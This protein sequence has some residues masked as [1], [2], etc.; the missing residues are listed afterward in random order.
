MVGDFSLG[1]ISI[2]VSLFL[3]SYLP[4]LTF[5]LQQVLALGVL[6]CIAFLLCWSRYFALA[7]VLGGDEAQCV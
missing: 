4:L 1:Y 6:L 3:R 5:L 7:G 2:A